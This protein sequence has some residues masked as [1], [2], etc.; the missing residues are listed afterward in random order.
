MKKGHVNHVMAREGRGSVESSQVHGD[1]L[2]V[3][4]EELAL[5]IID[6]V[7]SKVQD[8]S[9]GYR[10]RCYRGLRHKCARR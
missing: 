8:H 2:W 3:V 6:K 1:K 7:L 4:V 10:R 9:C 5:V